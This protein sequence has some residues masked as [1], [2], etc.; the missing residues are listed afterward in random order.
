MKNYGQGRYSIIKEND[1]DIKLKYGAF[2]DRPYDSKAIWG[3]DS[4]IQAI[5]KKKYNV[6]I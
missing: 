3:D 2:P 5:E 4:K 1:F 6:N